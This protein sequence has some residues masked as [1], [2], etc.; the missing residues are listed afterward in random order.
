VPILFWWRGV[1]G[2]Q[3]STAVETVDIAPTLAKLIGLE[4]P[5]Q[6]IDG[7]ALPLVVQ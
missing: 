2:F 3:Q 6:E 4:I 7:R 1:Q 5:P